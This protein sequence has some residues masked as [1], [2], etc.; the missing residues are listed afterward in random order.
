LDSRERCLRSIRL[1]EVDRIPTVL[2]CRAEILRALELELEVSGFDA[3]CDVLNVDVRHGPGIGLR[4][5]HLPQTG[6][7]KEG[8][9]V[10]SH[11]GGLEVRR[12][13]WGIETEWAPDHTYTYSYSY[14]P[15]A[16]IELSE[17]RWP[18][19][20][21]AGVKRLVEYRRRNEGH[22]V[23]AGVSHLFEQAWQLAGFNEFLVMMVRESSKA[24][25][26]LDEIDKIRVHEA[27]LLTEAGVDV[28]VDGDD[29]GAQ[30]SMIV[31]P[32]LW[33]RHLK[34]RYLKLIRIVKKRGAKFLFHSDGWVEPIIPDL[35]EVGVDILNP[36]QPEAMD[37]L[38]LKQR[39]GDKL[40]FDGTISIQRTLPFGTHKD[41]EDE[42]RKRI[43]ELGPTGLILG[44]SHDVQTDTSV[45]NL[46]AL[47]HAPRTVNV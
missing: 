45:G 32:A 6:E 27:E 14:H 24:C 13:V 41:V 36:V 17:Y 43:R 35:I 22:C 34:E 42:V 47:Y 10:V 20:D 2:R 15:L 25:R 33:R 7:Y 46:V 12:N 19:V 39:F 1:E 29:V 5:D 18:E 9:C 26:I 37:P 30:A 11:S 16:H 28:V 40:C 21:G 4:S 3:V 23:Y 8:G 44:P 38:S 31:S